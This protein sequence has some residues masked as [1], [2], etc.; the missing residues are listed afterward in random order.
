MVVGRSLRNTPMATDGPTSAGCPVHDNVRGKEVAAVGDAVG[1]EVRREGD[2][3]VA[4]CEDA[5][6]EQC[7]D[8]VR[9]RDDES[10]A[11]A[12]GEDDDKEDG[13]SIKEV[14]K[15]MRGRK[16]KQG[17]HASTS[18]SNTKAMGRAV[19]KK[20]VS[21]SVSWRSGAPALLLNHGSLFAPAIN[22]QLIL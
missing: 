14:V 1:V 3:V 15:V 16:W 13:G 7:A 9:K 17:P 5:V 22:P 12:E 4:D 6:D 11:D 10:D 19:N 2:K 21:R 8:S 18:T 20:C